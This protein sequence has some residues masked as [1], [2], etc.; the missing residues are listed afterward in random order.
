M[1]DKDW[2]NLSLGSC[3]LDKKIANGPPLESLTLIEWE[4]DTGTSDSI[5]LQVTTGN[6]VNAQTTI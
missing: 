1:G 4:N 6:G 2:Q 3:E 5:S